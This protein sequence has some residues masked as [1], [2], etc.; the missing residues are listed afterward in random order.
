MNRRLGV[1]AATIGVLAAGS[2]AAAGVAPAARP[3]TF[4]VTAACRSTDWRQYGYNTDHSFA[5][6]SGCSSISAAN[7]A[8]ML[9][10]W[11]F[12]TKD[13]V[14]AS[15]AVVGNSVYVG[16]WDGKF[17]SL[18]AKTGQ[19][20][21]VFDINVT[22]PVAFGQIVSSAA[23]EPFR[24]AGTHRS[25]EVVIFGGSSSVWALAADTGKLLAS[26]DLDPRTAKLRKQQQSA[27]N[28]PTVEI[29]SS[30]AVADVNVD[31]R[32]Q[33][34]IFI[35]LDV[36]NDAGVGRTGIV[37]L[38]LL[39]D[40]EGKWR[41]KPLWKNDAETD[42]TYYGRHALTEGSGQGQGCGDVWSSPAVDP[43][44]GV[45]VY[46]VGNCDNPPRA[47][48]HHQNWSES[49]MAV[50]AATGKFL[51]RYAPAEHQGS[52]NADVNAAYLDDDFGSSVNIFRNARGQTVAGDGSKASVYFARM[53][54]SGRGL[55]QTETGSPGNLSED[56]AVGGFIGS[57]AV[58]SDARGRATQI[59]GGTAIPVPFKS[60][61]NLPGAIE[62]IHSI[63]ANTGK[64]LWSDRLVA[65]TYASASTVN[66]I[67]LL[68]LTVASSV[69]AVDL[70]TGLPL[71]IGPIVGPPSSTAV[72]SGSS[73]YVGTGTNETD[74]EYKALNLAIPPA[75]E[76][77]IGQ[78]P[79]SPLS[80]VQAFQLPVG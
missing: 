18:N 24:V 50:D 12:H 74:L 54:R 68:P 33:R 67:A 6:P 32:P 4:H 70:K 25:Q 49:L 58:A 46:G 43:A 26:I 51:W 72:V 37:A 31:G 7:V 61:G 75:L 48:A 11:F 13:S 3:G 29:E 55:W 73:I 34:R 19:Q 22:N 21:W 65:P 45:M 42:R 8:T 62:N 52:T 23:V 9:P 63:D 16:A 80:G 2:V 66:D 71:W 78:S 60:G 57:L 69:V 15:P 79:L 59:V 10:K 27:P 5:V 56:F 41:F 14:T 36:H 76:R 53:A 35:G 38:R 20:Q 30:P 64:V 47:R 1:W 77:T 17:Y 39:S 40:P 28:P 44:S